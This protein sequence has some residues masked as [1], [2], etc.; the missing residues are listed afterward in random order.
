MNGLVVAFE[1]DLLFVPAKAGQAFADGGDHV[2]KAA[3]VCVDVE[4]LRHAGD[5]LGEDLFFDGDDGVN[6]GGVDCASLG[7]V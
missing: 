6:E 3:D 2:V 4:G 5:L 7:C 1:D